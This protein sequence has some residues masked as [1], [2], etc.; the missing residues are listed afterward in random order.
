M[1]GTYKNS[2]HIKISYTST[3]KRVQIPFMSTRQSWLL[4]APSL[5]DTP[6]FQKPY[7]LCNISLYFHFPLT[8][9]NSHETKN[10]SSITLPLH[11]VIHHHHHHLIPPPHHLHT[12]RLQSQWCHVSPRRRSGPIG[13]Q[14]GH[15]IRPVRNAEELDTGYGLLQ[16]DWCR[17]SL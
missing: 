4:N 8:F 6:N 16:M 12:H 5:K 10:A 1:N 9:Q 3:L 11:T 17:M 14:I 13:L 2:T 7:Y 15:Q